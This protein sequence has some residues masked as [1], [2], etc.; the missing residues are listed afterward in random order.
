MV[1]FE[2]YR[3]FLAV[4]RVGTVTG[5]ALELGLT[6]PAVTQHV[7][8][9]EAAVGKPLFTRTPR[10]MAPTERGKALYTQVAQ[11]LETLEHVSRSLRRPPDATLPL[12]RLGAPREYFA[13]A[14]LARLAS[15]Q[16]RVHVQFGATRALLDALRRDD[17]DLIIATERITAR[18]VEY[19]KLEEERFVLIGGPQATP[20]VV[21]P[22]TDL[23]RDALAAW[24]PAQPWVVYGPDLPIVR[25]FWRQIFSRRPEIEPTLIIPDL[26]LIVQ[27]VAS[28]FG[29]SVA[30]FYLCEQALAD[31][32]IQ[33]LW[34]PPNPVM[35]DL[36]LAYRT[37]DRLRPEIGDAM[38]ALQG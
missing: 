37:R 15:V 8:A 6:Q 30:P 16:L 26:L 7:A 20:P 23:Q 25:R 27:A 28:G 38:T 34:D 12:L 4:Y 9:L 2:W 19:R 31:G 18:E 13:E 10:H 21:Q 32:R 14:A 36:W 17:L 24:L 33:L 1:D 11:A 3:S 35:N 22:E 29:V 5:A